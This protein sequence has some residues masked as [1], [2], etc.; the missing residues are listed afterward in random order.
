MESVPDHVVNTIDSSHVKHLLLSLYVTFRFFDNFLEAKNGSCQWEKLEMIEG[1]RKTKKK[2]N[3]SNYFV[4]FINYCIIIYNSYF[5]LLSKIYFL[6]CNY[7]LTQSILKK[8]IF[9]G[10]QC[11]SFCI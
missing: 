11:V 6:S 5:I 10:Y 4:Y 8:I 7:T 3:P 9:I 2:K 1:K